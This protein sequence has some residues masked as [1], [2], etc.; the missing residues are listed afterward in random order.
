M[1]RRHLERCHLE[2]LGELGDAERAAGM[3]EGRAQEA[4]EERR[5]TMI[6][7]QEAQTLA[8]RT[9]QIRPTCPSSALLHALHT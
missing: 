8:S 4:A 3:A 5:K 6:Q 7:L 1:G 9:L 2:M